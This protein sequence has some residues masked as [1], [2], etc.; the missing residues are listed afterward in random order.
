MNNPNGV[1]VCLFVVCNSVGLDCSHLRCEEQ[2]VNVDSYYTFESA[3]T[4]TFFSNNS[5]H[6]IVCILSMS[7]CGA[8]RTAPLNDMYR[9]GSCHG[10]LIGAEGQLQH[11]ANSRD[12]TDRL[13]YDGLQIYPQCTLKVA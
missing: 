3:F 8:E 7:M 12:L 1:V 4:Y 5:V 9:H 11:S 6:I 2:V 10:E 13:T